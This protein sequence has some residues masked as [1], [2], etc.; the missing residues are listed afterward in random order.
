M[1]H[2]CV[3]STRAGGDQQCPICKVEFKLNE[4]RAEE[5][6]LPYWHEA[7]IGAA[8]K[9]AKGNKGVSK[10]PEVAKPPF[11]STRWPSLEE[12]QLY[13]YSTVKDWYIDYR[14]DQ[15][16]TFEVFVAKTYFNQ[17]GADARGPV[18]L[19]GPRGQRA[20]QAEPRIRDPELRLDEFAADFAELEARRSAGRTKIHQTRQLWLGKPRSLPRM[21]KRSSS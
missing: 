5:G 9:R 13:G 12:A 21:R 17:Q 6:E 4:E 14:R 8:Q 1:H 3:T 7:E 16:R 10:S 19:H 18:S 15:A 20:P 2:T 11:P